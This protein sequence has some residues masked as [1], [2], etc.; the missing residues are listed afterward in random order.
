M[1]QE[2]GNTQAL[3]T[4][5]Q[6]HDPTKIFEPDRYGYTPLHH[7]IRN[8][9]SKLVNTLLEAYPDNTE[10]LTSTDIYGETILH[11]ALAKVREDYAMTILDLIEKNIILICFGNLSTKTFYTLLL[12]TT[13]ISHEADSQHPRNPTSRVSCPTR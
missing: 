12:Y 7:A 10:A 8:N 11:T 6:K 13:K 1:I 5:L 2:S 4:A 9:N 3:I